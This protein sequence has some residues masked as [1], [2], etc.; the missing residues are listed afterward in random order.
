MRLWILIFATLAVTNAQIEKE[1][2]EIMWRT[3]EVNINYFGNS[4][5]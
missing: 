1:P 2:D 3:L 5:L 4:G